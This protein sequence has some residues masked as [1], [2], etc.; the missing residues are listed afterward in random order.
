MLVDLK[1]YFRIVNRLFKTELRFLS[2]SITIYGEPVLLLRNET[3]KESETEN[4]QFE[5][6]NFSAK[7]QF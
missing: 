5:E 3:N 1:Q 6:F 4:Q 7:P 2:Y